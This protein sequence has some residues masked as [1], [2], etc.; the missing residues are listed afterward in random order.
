MN[1]RFTKHFTREEAGR[2]IPRLAPRMIELQRLQKRLAELEVRLGPL[3]NGQL[4]VGG[5]S[6]NEPLKIIAQ[7]KAVEHEF[8]SLGV[9]I[10]EI[11]RGMADFPTIVGGKEAMLCWQL[12]EDQVDRW[13]EMDDDHS[14][15]LR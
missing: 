15:P 13:H 5:L 2:L 10:R 12:G 4:D 1:T 3:S 14:G 8:L 6:V 11:E 7:M 9:V